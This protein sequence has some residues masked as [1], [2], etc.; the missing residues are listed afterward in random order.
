MAFTADPATG[1]L[2]GYR[3]SPKSK[4]NSVPIGAGRPIS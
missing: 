4:S 3:W 2:T 1:A